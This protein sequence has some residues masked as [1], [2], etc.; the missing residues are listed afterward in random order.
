[1]TMNNKK[2]E[3]SLMNCFIDVYNNSIPKADFLK[4]IDEAHIDETGRKKIPFEDYQIDHK[5]LDEIII[6]H[7]KESKIPKHLHSAFKFQVYL[8]PSPKSINI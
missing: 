5:L 6:K 3:K 7:I 2:F 4:L 8:G 1:M